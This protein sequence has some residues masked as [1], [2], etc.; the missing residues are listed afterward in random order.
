[1]ICI[2]IGFLIVGG[3]LLG[4]LLDLFSMHYLSPFFWALYRIR[5]ERAYHMTLNKTPQDEEVLSRIF[6]Q[7]SQEESASSSECPRPT[8]SYSPQLIQFEKD[9]MKFI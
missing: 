7:N 6:A 4:V 8:T 2:S 3:I 5:N 1:M 9:Y